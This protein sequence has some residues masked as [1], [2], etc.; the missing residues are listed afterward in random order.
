MH[1]A[2]IT[3]MI[4]KNRR[5]FKMLPAAFILTIKN[6]H[7]I[8]VYALLTGFA[9]IPDFVSQKILQLLVVSR[10]AFGAA[11]AVQVKG[12]VFDFETVKKQ[13]QKRDN[14][15]I[16]RRIR[17]SEKLNPKLMEFAESAFLHLLVAVGRDIIK[18]FC[19]LGQ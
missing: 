9:H 16:S 4:Q 11:N 6:T 10:P 17:R 14:L 15:R 5:L 19:G 12:E 7:G 13:N 1:P 2:I 3:D 18:Q 8:A